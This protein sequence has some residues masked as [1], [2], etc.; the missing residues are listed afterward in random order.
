[1]PRRFMMGL[2]DEVRKRRGNRAEYR[3][4]TRGVEEFTR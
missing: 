4:I 2:V 1:M 3:F